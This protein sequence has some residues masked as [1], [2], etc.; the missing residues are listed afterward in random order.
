MKVK[1][2]KRDALVENKKPKQLRAS[3]MTNGRGEAK[4]L[5]F[6]LS[7]KK[8]KRL[9]PLWSSA[10]IVFSIRPAILSAEVQRA[11]GQGDA[12]RGKCPHCS[13]FMAALWVFQRGVTPP[14]D[15]AVV[16]PAP[17]PTGYT[18]THTHTPGRLFPRVFYWWRVGLT[19][20]RGARGGAW[21]T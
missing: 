10:G 13:T 15:T 6:L 5:N 2:Q 21:P 18:Q 4:G 16:T 1:T 3:Y 8:K 9:P 11:D 17:L 14:K 19:S 12:W 20:S 7:L